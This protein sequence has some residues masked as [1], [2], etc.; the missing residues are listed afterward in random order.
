MYLAIFVSAYR[1]WRQCADARMG[2]VALSFVALVPSFMVMSLTNPV[3]GETVNQVYFWALA[4]LTVAIHR[5]A[6]Q[7]V[8]NSFRTRSIDAVPER[9]H[10]GSRSVHRAVEL[11]RE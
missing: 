3:F 10:A 1:T 11:M 8:D 6:I 2:A 4:G 7:P 5:L 9:S